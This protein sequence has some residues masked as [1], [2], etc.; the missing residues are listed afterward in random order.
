[1]TR[2]DT[3]GDLKQKIAEAIGLDMNEFIIR[4]F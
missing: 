3:V 4:R 1:M 2:N